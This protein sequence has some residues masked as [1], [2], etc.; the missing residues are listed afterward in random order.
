MG[1]TFSNIA[2]FFFCVCPTSYERAQNTTLN[3][4]KPMEINIERSPQ[5]TDVQAGL[6]L[7]TLCSREQ[8]LN[9]SATAPQVLL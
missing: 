4:Y 6:E 3:T 9:R 7:E 2:K 8:C 5:H 1:E